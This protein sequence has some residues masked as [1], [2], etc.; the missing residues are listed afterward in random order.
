M[1]LDTPTSIH[2]TYYRGYILYSDKSKFVVTLFCRNLGNG[3]SESQLIA[4]S[5]AG[6]QNIQIAQLDI[7]RDVLKKYGIPG[8]EYAHIVQRSG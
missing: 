5:G 6:Q 7:V 2:Y 1:L 4:L 8:Y 3:K